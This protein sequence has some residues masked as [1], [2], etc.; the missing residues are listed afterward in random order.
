MK[1]EFHVTYCM[2]AMTKS[3][4]DGQPVSHLNGWRAVDA[5]LR[6]GSIAAAAEGLGVTNAAIAAQIRR[7]EERLDRP[8]FTRR[9]G[10]LDPVAD[11]RDEA[12]RLRRSLAGIAD[13]QATLGATADP[14][15]IS[16][17]V[18]Q[19]FAETWLPRHMSELFAHVGA[20]DLRLNTTWDVIDLMQSDVH[21]AIRYCGEVGPELASRDLLPSGLVPVCTQA[22]AERYGLAPGQRSLTGI[23]IVHIDVP[24]SDPDW[25][26]WDR[27]G[28]ATGIALDP[29]TT[30]QTFGL[31]GSGERIARAGI[32]LV[33]GG[34]SECLHAVAEGDLIMPFGAET[35]VAGQYWHRLVWRKSRRLSPLQSR[36]RDW[37]T[38]TAARDRALLKELFGV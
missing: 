37:I 2:V 20:I 27:W 26:E 21:F 10:G 19:T 4:H 23:P 29:S 16:L 11:L 6:T 15:Q 12:P 14:R 5:V 9:P 38:D 35:V 33:L 18:T 30:S 17:S 25:A 22:F 31:S 1:E 3:I 7:L 36:L 28:R 8:L 32:G 34:L 13:V 24:T